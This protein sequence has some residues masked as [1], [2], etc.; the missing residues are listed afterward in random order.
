MND[1]ELLNVAKSLAVIVGQYANPA[2]SD[3][4]LAG[5]LIER[6]KSSDAMR[7]RAK[8]FGLYHAAY[9]AIDVYRAQES[10]P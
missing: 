6:V 1:P 10:N 8:P 5:V 2:S 4:E 7:E 9:A 3:D